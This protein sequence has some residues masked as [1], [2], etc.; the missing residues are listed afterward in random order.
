MSQASTDRSR[1]GGA[2]PAHDAVEP[3]I[4][5]A[6]RRVA[7]SGAMARLSGHSAHHPLRVIVT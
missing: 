6:G 7:H 2:A 5:E 1:R 3:D 4:V